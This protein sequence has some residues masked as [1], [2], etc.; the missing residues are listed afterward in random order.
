[1]ITISDTRGFNYTK[2]EFMSIISRNFGLGY[3]KKYTNKCLLFEV[4]QDD[5]KNITE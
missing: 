2:A 3:I 5:Y 4:S 1:M